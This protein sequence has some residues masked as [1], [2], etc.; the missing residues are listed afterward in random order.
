MAGSLMDTLDKE[1]VGYERLPHAHTERAADEA[2]ALGVPAAEVGKTLVLTTPAGYV[3]V[4]LPASER[5]DLRKVGDALGVGNKQ[6][7]LSTE[8]ALARDYPEFDLGAV[9]P[10]GGGRKDRVLIDRRLAERESIVVEA[11]SHDESLRIP[12]AD[13]VRVAE[14]EVVDVCKE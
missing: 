4:V 10:L 2:K 13:L 6:V 11:G 1:G 12:T 5:L 8:D 7:H 14:A 9:P 3:R